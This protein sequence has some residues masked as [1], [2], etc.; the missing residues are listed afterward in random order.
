MGKLHFM[1]KGS[2]IFLDKQI[3]KRNQSRK[4]RIYFLQKNIAG[5]GYRYQNGF[6]KGKGHH[7]S[8]F[9][10][11]WDSPFPFASYIPAFFGNFTLI[12]DGGRRISYDIEVMTVFIKY[13]TKGAVL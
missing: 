12:F 5:M 8:F 6:E 4:R 2:G 7:G 9:V 10:A 13:R 11:L 1:Q 3:R